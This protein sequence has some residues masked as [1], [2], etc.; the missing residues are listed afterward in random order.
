[1]RKN[2]INHWPTPSES[3]D[4]NPIERI[5]AALKH[6]I[7]GKVKPKNKEELTQGIRDYWANLEAATCAKYIGRILKDA[8]LIVEREGGPAGH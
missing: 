5:W 3:P 6:Y 7:R 1:M 2:K 4:L 8:K